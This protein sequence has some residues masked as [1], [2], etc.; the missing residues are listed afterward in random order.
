[1]GNLSIKAG[2]LYFSLTSLSLYL[3]NKEFYNKIAY[4]IIAEIIF[5][6][7][8]KYYVTHILDTYSLK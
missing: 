7:N 2:I 5:F 6:L 8:D 4:F 1:M 3:R